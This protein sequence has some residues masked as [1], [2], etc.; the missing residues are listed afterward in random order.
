MHLDS[1]SDKEFFDRYKTTQEIV[2]AKMSEL[3]QA[4][5]DRDF[6]KRNALYDFFIELL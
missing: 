5:E 3:Q 2:W 6:L 4:V 1:M